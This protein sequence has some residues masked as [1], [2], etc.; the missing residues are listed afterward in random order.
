MGM[1]DKGVSRSANG[2]GFP[3]FKVHTTSHPLVCTKTNLKP[4]DLTHLGRISLLRLRC[5]TSTE[6]KKA[7]LL[8]N[9]KGNT[10]EA[11]RVLLCGLFRARESIFAPNLTL[12]DVMQITD[13][14]HSGLIHFTL[15][16]SNSCLYF[17]RCRRAD[18]LIKSQNAKH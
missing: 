17:W 5:R 11:R 10:K 7:N 4:R 18:H 1:C 2:D 3:I 15:G 9:V 6:G 14:F 12:A 13:P 8:D 16:C